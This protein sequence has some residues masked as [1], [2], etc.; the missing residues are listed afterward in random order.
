MRIWPGYFLRGALV[1]SL[2][3]GIFGPTVVRAGSA[4]VTTLSAPKFTGAVTGAAPGTVLPPALSGLTNPALTGSFAYD[5]SQLGSSTPGKDP[6]TGLANE[7]YVFTTP[8]SIHE[9]LSFNVT[10]T[11]FGD[12]YTNG[13]FTITITD[14]TGGGAKLDIHAI[15]AVQKYVSGTSGP[16]EQAYIDLV[17]TAAKYSGTALP[18]T[19]TTLALFNLTNGVLTWDPMTP[20]GQEGLVGTADT[21]L[22]QLGGPGGP[23]TP[24]PSGLVLAAIAVTTGSAGFF[25]ARRKRPAA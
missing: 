8:A 9:G 15:T 10:G 14:L 24:E 7:T 21:D 16:T 6:I 2:T 19:T 11:G 18:T 25:F 17:F 23:I 22:T 12:A 20:L 1:M 13:A 3:A 5:P 4:T